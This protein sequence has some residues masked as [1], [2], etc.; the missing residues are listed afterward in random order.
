MITRRDFIKLGGA[1]AAAVLLSSKFGFIQ[2]AFAEYVANNTLDPTSITKFTMPLVKPPAMPGKYKGPKHQFDIAMRQFQQQILPSSYPK[3]TVWSYG[4]TKDP[5]TVEEGGA[6][7][8]PAF[9]IESE[10]NK[11]TQVK[12]VNDLQD[13]KGNF[14]PH[15][16]PVDPSLHWANPIGRRDTRPNAI[17]DPDYWSRN[18]IDSNGNYSGPVPMVTHVHGAHVSEESDGYPEAWYLPNARKLPGLHRTGTFYDYYNTKYA[19]G[20]SS[21]SATFTYPNDQPATT[22]WYHDHTLG[23]TRVNVYAG[24]A[25]FWLIRG[26]PGDMVTDMDGNPA[27]LPGPAPGVGDNPFGTYYEIPIAFQDRSFKVDGSLLLPG[28]PGFLRRFGTRTA[29]NPLHL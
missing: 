15:L 10:W 9:T 12:W 2:K 21:G 19:Q 6:Y 11:P 13:S 23:M 28:H 18:Y 7:F 25:G 20:W 16:L 24:P 3:T 14:L 29:A 22:L 17:D 8:Y 5:R 1:S 4:P 27:I 26:G